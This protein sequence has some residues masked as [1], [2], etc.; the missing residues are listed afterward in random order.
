MSCGRHPSTLTA[1]PNLPPRGQQLTTQRF[2]PDAFDPIDG[3]TLEM[4][5]AICRAL[6]RSPGGSARQLESALGEH[7]LTVD[8]WTRLRAG[9]SARI[10][11]DPFVRGAFRRLFVGTVPAVPPMDHERT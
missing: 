9:W 10:A 11:G 4:Y 6:V 7:G 3:Y 8:L 5:A 2:N 1:F